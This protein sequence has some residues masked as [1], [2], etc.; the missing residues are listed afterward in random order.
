V[1]KSTVVVLVVAAAVLGGGIAVANIGKPDAGKAP[2]AI[3][4]VRPVV[5]GWD[6][7]LPFDDYRNST[8]EVNSI[9]RASAR[10]AKDCM[11]RFGL[12]WTVA[13]SD[14]ADASIAPNPGRYG[15]L[16]AAEVARWG[17]HVPEDTRP[18]EAEA[19]PA[20]PEAVMVYSGEG[21]SSFRGQA[22]PQ[23]GCLGEGRRK[24]A[25]GG[26]RSMSGA[27]FSE[28]DRSTSEAAR[29]DSRVVERM[30][31]WRKCMAE[32]G[33]DYTDV[34]AVNNDARWT[35]AA[36]SAEEIAT[37]NR[38]VACRAKSEL[39][40]VWLAVEAAYQR[41]AIDE[42]PADFAALK[43]SRQHWVDSAKRVLG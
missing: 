30:T 35:G 36:A 1:R 39:V 18:K 2:P 43:A 5:T 6:I 42:H 15:I 13:E 28:L 20:A 7:V 21:A 29:A 25:E 32:A 3:G 12:E 34:W 27:E 14:A 4:E 16:D 26:P 22:V 8:D 37:A 10:L 9:E 33:Y 24:L 11:G 38:D 17:Y 40:P 23:G 41:Q 19:P 31:S